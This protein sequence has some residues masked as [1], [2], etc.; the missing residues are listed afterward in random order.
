MAAKDEIDLDEKP[1]LAPEFEPF[2]DWLVDG[3]AGKWP[4]LRAY[5]FT[6]TDEKERIANRNAN[7]LTK[8]DGGRAWKA[9]VAAFENAIGGLPKLHSTSVLTTRSSVM[10]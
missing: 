9:H 10:A 8:S 4:G 5:G 7:L 6:P 3:T 2:S 1:W